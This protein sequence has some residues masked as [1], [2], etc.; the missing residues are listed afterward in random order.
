MYHIGIILP[1]PNRLRRE[2]RRQI[3][4]F[5]VSIIDGSCLDAVFPFNRLTFLVTRELRPPYGTHKYT[6]L[7]GLT[8]LLLGV[9]ADEIEVERTHT[10]QPN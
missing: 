9:G 6:G 7:N 4:P 5:R 10:S 2:T 1:I 3:K 8:T